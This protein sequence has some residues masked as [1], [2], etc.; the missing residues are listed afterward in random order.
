MRTGLVCTFPYS[1]AD[2]VEWEKGKEIYNITVH[3]T[4]DIVIKT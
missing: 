4:L 1:K 3:P 2:Y